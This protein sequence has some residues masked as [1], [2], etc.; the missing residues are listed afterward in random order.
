MILE[1]ML[2]LAGHECDTEKGHL[3][4]EST[5]LIRLLYSSIALKIELAKQ[6][7]KEK[8]FSQS[9]TYLKKAGSAL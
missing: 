1:L 9:T 2:P 3:L 8:G 4:H 5:L 7:I 6:V